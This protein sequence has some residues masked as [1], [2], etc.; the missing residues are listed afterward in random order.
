MTTTVR[1]TA[2]E[3]REAV[4]EAAAAEFAARGYEGTS[5]EKTAR[6]V[7]ILAAVHIPAV[8]NEA[9]PFRGDGPPLPD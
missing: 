2:V 5:T 1:L 7:G 3:R 6:R 8:R 9:E 4:L